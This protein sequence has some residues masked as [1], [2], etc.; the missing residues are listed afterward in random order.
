MIPP[1]AS[2]GRLVVAACTFLLVVSGCGVGDGSDIGPS[3]PDQPAASC[4]VVVLDDQGRGV[5]GAAVRVAG[6]TA[7]T[8]RNGRGDLLAEPRGR[9]LVAIDA[10][11]AAAANGDALP[12]FAVATTIT[13]PDLPAVL[14]VPD[15]SASATVVPGS[16]AAASTITTAAGAILTIRAGSSVGITSGAGNAVVRA[17][18]LRPEHLPGDLPL[19]APGAL[20]FTAGVWIDAP[21]VSFTPAARIDVADTLGSG[22]G[23]VRTF[24]FDPAAG[25]WSELATANAA[26]GRIVSD[27]AVTQTGLYAFAA[28]VPATSVTGRIVDSAGVVLLD[29]LVRV[30]QST[31]VTDRNG[32]FA[33]AGVP[34]A[35]ADG[36]ARSAA[37]E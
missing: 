15:L 33:A 36:S 2:R 4:K 28:A 34:A 18:D 31:T 26:G 32:V 12:A 7:L 35:L 16:Q 20:L 9:Q 8:G 37:V 17:G 3:L 27:V 1:R 22:N 11:D 13:G 10:R 21:A 25:E 14:H 29:V 5:V 23:Q 30:D 19:A 24:R 6:F